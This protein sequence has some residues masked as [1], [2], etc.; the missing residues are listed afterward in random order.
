MA[1]ASHAGKFPFFPRPLRQEAASKIVMR[2]MELHSPVRLVQRSKGQTATAAAAY[3]S[4][5][6][7]ECERT[8]E[9][10]DYTRKQG[11]ELNALL[12]P[13][14]TPEGIQ[15]RKSLWNA[16]EKR[17]K[18]PRAQTARDL[19]VSFPSEFS[20]EQRR[21]AGLAIGNMLVD[22]YGVAADL[23]WHKPSR[24]GD[25]RN[26]HL[27]ILFTTRR[28]ENGDW[29]KIK[30]R[31]LDDLKGKG[32]EEI[33]S[34]RQGIADVLN[35]IAARDGLAVYVEHLSFEKRG[36]DRE[37]TQ[38]LGHSATELE[39]R[40][41]QTDIGNKNREIQQRNAEREK[42]REER[43][44]ILAEIEQ[45]QR[46]GQGASKTQPQMPKISTQ[47]RESEIV[48]AFYQETQKRRQELLKELSGQYGEQERGARQELAQLFNAASRSKGIFG[49]W[50]NITGRTKREA[51]QIARLQANLEN[52]QK[53]R[54]EAFKGFERDRQQRLEIL[55]KQQQEREQQ[56]ERIPANDISPPVDEKAQKMEAFKNRMRERSAPHSRERDRKGLER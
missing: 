37:A 51:E 12:F 39:R 50:R 54:Q 52:I 5:S 7:I 41:I 21:E 24:K 36:I 34:L 4:G 22:R 23:C 33:T 40:G 55:K 56:P 42:L 44:A 11:I 38:H 15:D 29:S 6:R 53:Q 35:N 32:A 45:E 18:H 3:R 8:G 49:F 43:A 9:V 28:F 20:P 17:E 25:E 2:V 48:R 47:S 19:E 1:L 26:H 10:H 14:G 16:A 27:H 13:T 46:A 30:D 31:T